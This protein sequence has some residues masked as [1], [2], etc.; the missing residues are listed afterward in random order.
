MYSTCTPARRNGAYLAQDLPCCPLCP[1]RLFCSQPSPPKPA[2]AVHP[3]AKVATKSAE[4]PAS[5]LPV[6]YVSPLLRTA[7]ASSRALRPRHRQSAHHH[8][9]PP[10]LSSTTS[11]SPSPPS[12][13][14]AAIG[15]SGAGYNS[16]SHRSRAA[17]PGPPPRPHRR[18]HLRRPLQ[19]HPRSTRRGPCRAQSASP[20][21]CSNIEVAQHPHSR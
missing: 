15:I 11:S 2:A 14:T 4:T 3:I 8:R 20:V 9:L 18:P 19:R 5:Q 10:P 17:A 12:I 7:S 1:R 6:T 21:A 13:S 16:T